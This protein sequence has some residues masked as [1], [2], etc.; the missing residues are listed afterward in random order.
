MPQVK[1]DWKTTVTESLTKTGLI[2]PAFSGKL[3]V[4]VQDGG[5]RFVDISQTIK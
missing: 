4:T 3:L 1:S 2:S 5:I